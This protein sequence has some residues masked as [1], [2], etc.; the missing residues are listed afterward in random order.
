MKSQKAKLTFSLAIFSVFYLVTFH[1]SISFCAMN[2]GGQA[3]STATFF[4]GKTYNVNN[5]DDIADA[6]PGDGVC[7]TDSGN[8]VCTLRAAVQ[9]GNASSTHDKI[10]LKAGTYKLS[11]LNN[12]NGL[13][14]KGNLTIVGDGAKTTFI[15]GDKKER[16]FTVQKG[17]VFSLSGVTL[18]N[19]YATGYAAGIFNLGK[20]NAWNTNIIGNS[21]LG[22]WNAG[23]VMT[24]TN[25]TVG[26]NS[27]GGIF[28]D[29]ASMRLTNVTVSDN[30]SNGF[31]GG[32][33]NSLES[34]LILTNV[35]I[36]HNVNQI[37]AYLSSGL[38][39]SKFNNGSLTLENTI[40]AKNSPVDCAALDAPNAKWDSSLI[41]SKG[42][43]LDSDGSCNLIPDLRDLR[44]YK[45]FNLGPL[46]N[47]GGE[48]LTLALLPGNPAIDAGDDETC[49]RKDQRGMARY[50]A[51][52][53]IGAYEYWPSENEILNYALPARESGVALPH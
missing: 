4:Q 34:N 29:S 41:S 12:G 18:Q 21:G 8:G 45:D 14:I 16:I 13:D 51:H 39:F 40:V 43:N 6:N 53:D 23:G 10:I 42:H 22:I 44:G 26:N 24:L 1:S 33:I 3:A 36:F 31:G 25:S 28:L 27:N 32:G 30:N 37:Q 9:E 11:L 46:A 20:T 49:P 17:A 48:T 5:T 19:G 38:V 52:C 15:D 7:E 50:G 47:N 2:V 35:T